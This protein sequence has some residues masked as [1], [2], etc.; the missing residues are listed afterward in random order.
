M[1]TEQGPQAGDLG[2]QVRDHAR[3]GQARAHPGPRAHRP[4]PAS[5]PFG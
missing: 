1:L 5:P 4:G 3:R 2:L